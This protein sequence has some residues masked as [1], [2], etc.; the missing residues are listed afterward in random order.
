VKRRKKRWTKRDGEV[1]EKGKKKRRR[2]EKR[3]S[4]GEKGGRGS[5][6]S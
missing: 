3:R 4:V 6:L 5:H 1:L 2:G